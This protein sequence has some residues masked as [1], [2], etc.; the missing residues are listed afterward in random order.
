MRG[1]SGAETS[2]Y[3][4]KLSEEVKQKIRQK[5]SGPLNATY[6]IPVPEERKQKIREANLRYPHKDRKHTPE[7]IAKIAEAG[8][9]RI[10]SEETRA[11]LS[12]ALKGREIP[13]EQRLRTSRTLSGAGNFWY[14]KQRPDSFKEKIRKPVEAVKPDGEVKNYE[15][16]QAVLQDTGLNPPTVNRALK[17]GKALARGPLKGWAFRYASA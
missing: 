13:L 10:K 16:I 14:G 15:S 2:N 8:R 11:K 4:K 17:S 3:G 5:V 1:K 6:G 7:A 12:A 9:G